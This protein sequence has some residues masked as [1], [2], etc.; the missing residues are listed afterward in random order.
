LALKLEAV[1]STP[2]VDV[3]VSV[4]QSSV[5][6]NSP[7][8]DRGMID[9]PVRSSL[10]TDSN[11]P[12][13]LSATGELSST[14][15]PFHDDIKARLVQI[16]EFLEN[17]DPSI[18]SSG[19]NELAKLVKHCDASKNIDPG[20]ALSQIPAELP[21]LGAFTAVL[22]A[23]NHLQTRSALVIPTQRSGTGTLFSPSEPPTA[24]ESYLDNDQD[25]KDARSQGSNSVIH[26]VQDSAWGSDTECE[27]V[28]EIEDSDQ[29][30]L[31]YLD[32]ALSFIAAERAKFAELQESGTKGPRK[33]RRKRNV[34]LLSSKDSP[35]R[36]VP[37][38]STDVTAEADLDLDNSYSLGQLSLY[39]KS[40]PTTPLL[41]RKSP[42]KEKREQHLLAVTS[43]SLP[44]EPRTLQLRSLT[45]K[46][47]LLF[48]EN[49]A[50]LTAV[51]SSDS[52]DGADF[53][54]PRG[55]NP[56]SQDTLIHVF[57]DQLR[58]NFSPR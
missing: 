27:D 25:I 4:S 51:L 35:D 57:V 56:R 5:A 44:I 7:A 24:L 33:H 18:R 12:D 45:H 42:R 28:S 2:Q 32:E 16:V 47:R 22:L 3:E 8:L 36:M 6:L 9:I 55:P 23:L 40:S 15:Y 13:L 31:G 49:A 53:F 48:P 54:D 46:L 58:F 50:E 11:I 39:S 14:M 10:S 41:A 21:N 1:A 38:E 17:P 52:L 29:P 26:S 20:I 43:T 34:P 19:E 37:I 30:S